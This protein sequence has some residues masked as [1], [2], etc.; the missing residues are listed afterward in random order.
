MKVLIA[1]VMFLFG[2][3]VGILVVPTFKEFSTPMSLEEEYSTPRIKT[4]LREFGVT[5]PLEASDVNLYLKQDGL[6]KQ[7]WVKFE[8]SPE[9]RDDFIMQL[10]SKNSGL[11]NREIE[12]PKMLDGTPIT[13]WSYRESAPGARSAARYY[14]F[15]DMCAA[16]DESLHMIF[17]YAISDGIEQDTH[18]SQGTGLD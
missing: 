3:F 17:I 13:W 18:S 16:Y 9:V 15:H 4:I 12:T 11:F 7:L 6:K 10:S 5:L 2:L 14:E 8:C 1:I